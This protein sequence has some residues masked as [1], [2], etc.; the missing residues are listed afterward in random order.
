V[1]EKLVTD[2]AVIIVADVNTNELRNYKSYYKEAGTFFK[3]YAKYVA[4]DDP[5]PVYGADQTSFWYV[6]TE[7]I[8]KPEKMVI[9]EWLRPI[10]AGISEILVSIPVR[11]ERWEDIVASGN[12]GS[13]R[14]LYHDCWV[15]Q[16][17]WCPF[18][19]VARLGFGYTV[20][21]A[22]SVSHDVWLKRCPDNVKW[23]TNLD[24]FL[25]EEVSHD[26]NR[27]VSHLRSP[28]VVFLSHRSVDKAV[29]EQ[30]ASEIKRGGIAI[31]FDK[32]K[33]VPSDSLVGEISRGLERMTHFVLFWSKACVG[34]SWVEK[35]LNAATAKLIERHSL[36]R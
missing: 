2:G 20:F 30:V 10:Y 17:D 4:D 13:T 33:L 26:R 7:I 34:A 31:W 25:V 8:C 36:L 32:E 12:A 16:F 6:P 1:A 18:A 24:Q 15:D 3:A 19:S 29:V 9:S 14:I 5:D 28:F 11:L 22:G 21:I 23:L 27:A 35:E